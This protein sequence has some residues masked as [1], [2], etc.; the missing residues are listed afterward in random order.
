[1]SGQTVYRNQLKGYAGQR[2]G[3]NHDAKTGKN[4][5]GA[6]RQVDDITVD[7][8][9][10]TLYE[11]TVDVNGLGPITISADFSGGAPASV[12]VARDALIANARANDSFNGQVS[13]N[14]SG[15]DTIRITSLVIG[16][17]FTTAEAHASLSLVNVVTNVATTSIPFGRGV[18]WNSAGDADSIKLPD[19]AAQSFMGVLERTHSVVDP[20]AADTDPAALSALQVGTV[21]HKGQVIVEIEAVTVNPAASVFVRHTAGAGGTVLGRFRIDADT[22]TADAVA[23]AKWADVFTGPGLAVLSVD[24]A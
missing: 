4:D 16:A 7:A 2:V 1:M 18:V 5:T 10:A 6:V 11:F 8:A 3:C 21:I 15:T 9:A 19:A 23:N 24:I 20:A 14:Q 22:A 13:F 12:S 17:P